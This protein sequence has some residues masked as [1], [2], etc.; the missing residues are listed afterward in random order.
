MRKLRIRSLVLKLVFIFIT[1]VYGKILQNIRQR[2]LVIIEE[3]EAETVCLIISCMRLKWDI[4]RLYQR[5]YG[6]RFSL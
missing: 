3:T 6:I 5:N 4:K 1:L 2:D